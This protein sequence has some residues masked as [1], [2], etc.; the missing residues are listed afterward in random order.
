MNR[1]R[2]ARGRARLT[3]KQLAATVGTSQQAIQRWEAGG[4]IPLQFV[5]RLCAALGTAPGAL[6][7]GAAALRASQSASESEVAAAASREMTSFTEAADNGPDLSDFLL[8]VTTRASD[9]WGGAP[10][11]PDQRIVELESELSVSPMDELED[12]TFTSVA[13]LT[14]SRIDI[15]GLDAMGA[16]EVFD[17]HSQDLENLHARLFAKSG[18]FRNE[19]GAKSGNVIYIDS[20]EAL[21]PEFAHASAVECLIRYAVRFLATSSGVTAFMQRP[22]DPKDA[23]VA[24]AMTRL[25]AKAYAGPPRVFCLPTGL[26][27]GMD[28]AGPDVRFYDLGAPT[29]AAMGLTHPPRPPRRQP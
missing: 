5:P 8:H 15:E 10:E 25:G 4:D 3:Q 17:A 14:W 1:L 22:K 20:F 9:Q 13:K 11:E 29:R 12:D 24:D 23:L 26:V 21:T 2:E 16:W 6:I 19:I 7:P 18:R 27:R 28:D